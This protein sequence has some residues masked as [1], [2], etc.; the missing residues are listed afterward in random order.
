MKA[1]LFNMAGF[2]LRHQQIYWENL[3]GWEECKK[4]RRS[5][6]SLTSGPSGFGTD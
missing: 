2:N 1:S 4:L 3:D 6:K 5:L